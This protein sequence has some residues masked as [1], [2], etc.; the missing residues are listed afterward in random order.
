MLS[1]NH[2]SDLCRSVEATSTFYKR[3]LGFEEV[4]RPAFEFEGCWCA[5]HPNGMFV[6]LVCC[7][8]SSRLAVRPVCCSS[9]HRLQVI[10][11]KLPGQGIAQAERHTEASGYVCMLPGHVS[12]L[13]EGYTVPISQA[14]PCND[15]V[16]QRPPM[17]CHRAAFS[18]E[19]T[20]MALDSTIFYVELCFW[21]CLLLSAVFSL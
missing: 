9:S 1:I 11:P 3:V 8:S 5:Y 21:I 4:P 2:V 6:F 19:S 10:L 16:N 13:H 12:L 15:S 17:S 14:Q 18:I 20:Q 7:V